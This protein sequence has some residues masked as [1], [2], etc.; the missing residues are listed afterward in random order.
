MPNDR[1]RDREQ[2][3]RKEIEQDR[4]TI[5]AGSLEE[6]KHR[7]CRAIK[8]ELKEGEAQSKYIHDGCEISFRASIAQYD[9]RS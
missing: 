4:H 6:L 9:K 1:M 8:Y 7:K 3:D 5:A 2:D